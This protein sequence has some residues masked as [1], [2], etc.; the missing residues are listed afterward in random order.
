MTFDGTKDPDAVLDYVWDWTAWLTTD[1]TIETVTWLV[2]T[3]ITQGTTSN[4]DNTATIWLSG[5]TLDESYPITC[6]ITTNQDRTDDRTR[7][8][9]VRTR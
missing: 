3:G 7:T 2:P 4:T 8:I 5:G 1:E 6:R 9:R